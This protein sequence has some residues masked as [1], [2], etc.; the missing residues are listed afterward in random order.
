MYCS[1]LK[2][3]KIQQKIMRQPMGTFKHSGYLQD[4]TFRL[5]KHRRMSISELTAQARGS[6][7]RT[8]SITVLELQFVH[9]LALCYKIWR[10]WL[11]RE[12]G[13][14][15]MILSWSRISQFIVCAFYK[16]LSHT[17]AVVHLFICVGPRMWVKLYL[18]YLCLLEGAS[19]TC[20]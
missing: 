19:P 2:E 14:K 15:S 3:E 1:R 8:R 13:N 4:T 18:L 20:G 7:R 9:S 10:T 6:G 16:Y 12:T 5:L 17:K 11:G